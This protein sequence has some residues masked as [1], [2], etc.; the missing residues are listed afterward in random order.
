MLLYEATAFAR[1]R[2]PDHSY[3]LSILGSELI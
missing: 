2:C 3:E 1:E